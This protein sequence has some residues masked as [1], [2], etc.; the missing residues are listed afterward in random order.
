MII[1]PPPPALF[2]PTSVYDAV[3]S[4]SGAEVYADVVTAAANVRGV[5]IA[6]GRLTLVTDATNRKPNLT[7]TVDYTPPMMIPAAFRIRLGC[8]VN[9]SAV[10]NIRA[11]LLI[12]PSDVQIAEAWGD[13]AAVMYGWLQLN[14][15]VL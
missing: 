1:Q 13:Y 8:Q 5:F 2:S 14:Y 7:G 6:R 9:A 4:S 15:R 10:S 11:R 3:T 12:G